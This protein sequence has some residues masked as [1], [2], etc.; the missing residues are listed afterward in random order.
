[1]VSAYRSEKNGCCESKKIKEMR[2]MKLDELLSSLKSGQVAEIVA[3]G[4]GMDDGLRRK[5]VAMGLLPGAEVH[6]IRCAPWGGPMQIKLRQTMLSI[7]RCDAEHL[8]VRVR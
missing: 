2:D 5:L 8:T 4:D 7:R 1:M 6:C 3:L